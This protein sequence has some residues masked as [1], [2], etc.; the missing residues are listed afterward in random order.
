MLYEYSM[1]TLIGGVTGLL[2]G[3]FGGGAD[4]LIV[5]LLLFFKVFKDIK[6]AVGTSLAML[7]PPVGILAVYS[8]YKKGS[9]NIPYAIYLAIV[10]TLFS[11]FSANWGLGLTDTVIQKGYAIFLG[12][13][14]VGIWFFPP[15]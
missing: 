6:M 13:V 10:F 1:L 2:A 15:A 12:I 3:V 8:Y 11:M 5:P 14:A 9:V 4:V 7:L